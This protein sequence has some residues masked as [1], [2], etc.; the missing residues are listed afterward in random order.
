MDSEE[1]KEVRAVIAGLAG[2]FPKSR[3]VQVGFHELQGPVVQS[4]VS[5]MSSLR[6]QFIKCFTILLASTLKFLSKKLEK[7][8]HCKSFSIFFDKNSAI[9]EI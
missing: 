2:R 1:E 8:L 5:L 6:G 9:Y 3:N 4:I 7:L